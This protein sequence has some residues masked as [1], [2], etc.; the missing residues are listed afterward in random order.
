MLNSD[1]KKYLYRIKFIIVGFF[2]RELEFE[3]KSIGLQS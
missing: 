3:V 1:I 2:I